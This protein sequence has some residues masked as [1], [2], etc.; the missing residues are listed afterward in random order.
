MIPKTI[1]YIWLG[2]GEKSDTVK[3]CIESW[4]KILPDYEVKCWDE[5]NFDIE[6]APVFVKEAYTAK[7]W[8]FAADYVRMW[9]LYNYGGIYLDT[10]EE[11][12]KDLGPY[13]ENRFFIGTQCYKT[14]ESKHKSEMHT[15]LSMGVIGSE[16]KH[17]YMK[18]LLDYYDSVGFLAK[19]GKVDLTTTNFKLTEL[20]KEFGY[21]AEDKEQHL[22]EGIAVYPSAVFSDRTSHPADFD[23][24]SYHW[25]EMSWF[26]RRPRGKFYKL[27]WNLDLMGFYHWVE[28]IRQKK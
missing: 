25:G 17:P 21:V 24:V 2:G 11:V 14:Q 9:V 12:R 3:R 20:M 4:T 1:H 22:A 26:V 18:K 6:S 5:S 16:P 27:C 23:C 13:L 15:Y 8:A 28:R 19:D 7:K 10:D